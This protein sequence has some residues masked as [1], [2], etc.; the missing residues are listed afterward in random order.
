MLIALKMDL[1]S[2]PDGRAGGVWGDEFLSNQKK[3]VTL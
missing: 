2:Y 1:Q 3:V